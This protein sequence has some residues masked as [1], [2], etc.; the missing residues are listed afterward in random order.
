MSAEHIRLPDRLNP[1][2]GQGVGDWIASQ[3]QDDTALIEYP[4]GL[5]FFRRRLSGIDRHTESTYGDC[6]HL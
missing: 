1:N 5:P 3:K 4:T 2:V 6:V